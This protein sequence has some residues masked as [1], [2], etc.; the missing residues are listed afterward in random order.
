MKHEVTFCYL[1]SF[2]WLWH[3]FDSFLSTFCWLFSMN[4]HWKI[5]IRKWIV[6]FDELLV[7]CSTQRNKTNFC[8]TNFYII[9][10][11]A[12]G[13]LIVWVQTEFLKF[14]TVSGHMMKCLLNEYGQAER[15]NIWPSVRMYG[16]SAARSVRPDLEWNIFSSGPPTHSISTYYYLKNRAYIVY[17]ICG[18]F[19]VDDIKTVWVLGAVAVCPTMQL[20]ITIITN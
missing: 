4:C 15:E 6:F 16:P 20:N 2:W 17:F 18:P 3:I 1:P 8:Y 7:P 9:V 11:H 13:C 5:K 12:H 10:L 14:S 19:S